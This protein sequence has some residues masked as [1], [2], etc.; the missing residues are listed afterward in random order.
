MRA[1]W[2]VVRLRNSLYIVDL[3]K[4]ISN[5]RPP[6]SLVKSW[7]LGVYEVIGKIYG[8]KWCVATAR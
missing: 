2:H 1:F 3:H 8:N 7:E 5:V 4:G 6:A